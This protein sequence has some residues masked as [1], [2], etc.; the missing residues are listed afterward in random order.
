MQTKKESVQSAI[1]KAAS[2]EFLA[3]GFEHSSMRR[4]AAAAN[5]GMSNFYNYF[6]SK[7]ALFSYIVA[8]RAES[9]SS[10]F[11]RLLAEDAAAAFAGITDTKQLLH[12]LTRWCSRFDVLFNRET[13]LLLTAADGTLFAD[14]RVKM[15]DD[16]TRVL[17]RL[18]GRDENADVGTLF[19]LRVY[20]E[21]LLDDLLATAERFAERA[22][23]RDI[24]R[25]RLVAGVAGLYLMI[26]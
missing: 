12:N 14:T 18:A 25:N 1:V 21:Q 2:A 9:I 5:T 3:Y 23:L 20:V 13:R 15:L 17:L 7:E 22:D 8:D 26:H 11:R 16:M 19:P 4:M 6:R 10:L 24:L